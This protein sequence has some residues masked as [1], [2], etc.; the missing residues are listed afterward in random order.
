MA[1]QFTTTSTFPNPYIT[2][3]LNNIALVKMINGERKDW[4]KKYRK[5][6]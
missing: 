3:T 6:I 4:T 5:I 1:Q 2:Y